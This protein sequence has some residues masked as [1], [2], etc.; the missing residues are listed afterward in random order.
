MNGKDQGYQPAGNIDQDMQKSR[1]IRTN[2]LLS[3]TI[4]ASDIKGPVR[5]RNLSE[6][7][8]LLE[9][10]ALPAIG[11]HLVLKR[12]QMEMGATVV[13]SE[14][15][16]CGIRFDGAISVSGW[17]EGNWI[18][19]VVSNDQAR[20]DR[21]QAAVRAGSLAA[22]PEDVPS[23][24]ALT[25]RDIDIG[26]AAE[27]TALK[28]M[29]ETASEQLSELPAVMDLHVETLQNFDVACQTLRHLAAVLRADSP[30]PAVARIG[31]EALR[32]RLER[33]QRPVASG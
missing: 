29:L 9:G 3:G 23:R 26:I 28:E 2:L 24:M 16:R 10:A 30:Q 6:T 12:L 14:S 21:I 1:S 22:T 7:G 15:G 13:W 27:L 11:H 5:I 31:M 32:Q 20:A 25:E 17:R 19:P 8:A 18:A 33:S 4:E